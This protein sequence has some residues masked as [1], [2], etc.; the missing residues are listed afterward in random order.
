EH[1]IYLVV[2]PLAV[3]LRS[4]DR[5][6]VATWLGAIGL[7]GLLYLYHYIRVKT[8]IG[9]ASGD[10]DVSAWIYGGYSYLKSMLS[11]G[12]FESYAWAKSDAV[13]LMI[14]GLAILGVLLVEERDEQLYLLGIIL[15]PA[16]ASL[17]I[18][19]KE[20]GDYWGIMYVPILLLSAP[21]SL[22]L[23][24]SLCQERDSS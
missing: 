19:A 11:F 14:L 4:R 10:P 13:P 1:F 23:M 15:T 24:P 18:G 16:L 12:L 6:R 3:A 8:Y 17:V 5:R 2:M 22:Q 21:L 9:Q 7:F 20:W